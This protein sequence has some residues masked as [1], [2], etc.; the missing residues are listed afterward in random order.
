MKAFIFFLGFIAGMGI[1][2]IVEIIFSPE[3][4]ER[5][6]ILKLPG[7]DGRS[8]YFVWDRAADAY[9]THCGEEDK[10]DWRG[11]DSCK[12]S[13]DG[14]QSFHSGFLTKDSAETVLSEYVKEDR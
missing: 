6:K 2:T 7:V 10:K 3:K 12:W 1:I 8:H 11:A 5:F 14:T 9:I 4:I 13:I